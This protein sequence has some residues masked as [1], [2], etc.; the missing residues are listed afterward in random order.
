MDEDL[1]AATRCVVAG[2]EAQPGAQVGAPLVL[3]STYRAGGS[4]IYGRT[5]HPTW[6]AFEE[7]LG[8]LEG[9]ESLVYSSGMAAV[10]AVLSLVPLGGRV[11]APTAAYNGVLSTLAHREEEGTLTVN[12]V[13]PTDAEGV[14]RALEGADLLWLESPSNPLLEVADIRALAAA[15]AQR[16]VLCAVDNT[17]ATPLGQQPLALGADLVVHSVTKYLAGHSDVVL[18][19]VVTGPTAAGRALRERLARHRTLHGAVAGPLET[20]LALRG[21]RTLHLRLERASAN[22]AELVRRLTG[23]PALERVRYPG[24]GA[25]VSV[26]VAG[27]AEAAE[28]VCRRV[29]LWVPST[30]LGGVESQVERRRRWESESAAVPEGLLRLSVGIEDV[31]DLW[32]DLDSALRG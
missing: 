23:H 8:A 29:R 20:W 24:C 19:A 2:R 22:A 4:R 11:V 10:A 32:R 14:I 16:G 7:A 18:G 1:S 31:G 27:G 13:D 30:S 6:E 3:T 17:F 12:R 26:D 25:I 5:E 21:L 9:G 28:A 15:A